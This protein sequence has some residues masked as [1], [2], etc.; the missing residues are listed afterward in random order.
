M[1]VGTLL[2]GIWFKFLWQVLAHVRRHCA[3]EGG[4]EVRPGGFLHV[5]AMMD[6]SCKE[7]GN[8]PWKRF[9]L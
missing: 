1:H 7:L 3:Q 2:C 6:S 4:L 5:Q 8:Q 9:P